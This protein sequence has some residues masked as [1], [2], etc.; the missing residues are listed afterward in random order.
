V[1]GL[2]KYPSGSYLI[3]VKLADRIE[4]LKL[5]RQQ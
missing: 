2:E 4:T 5:L 1:D 3:R